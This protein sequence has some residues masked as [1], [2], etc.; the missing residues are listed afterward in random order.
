[1][2]DMPNNLVALLGTDDYVGVEP[3]AS[4]VNGK[5]RYIILDVDKPQKIF[6]DLQNIFNA[7]VGEKQKIL[8]IQFQR[9]GEPIPLN[10][11]Q[12]S[13]DGTYPS[14][15]SFH[16]VG[17]VMETN[18]PIVQFVMLDGMFQE[19]GDYVF[20]FSIQNTATGALET[21]HNCFFSVGQN[22]NSLAIDWNN[23][24]NPYDSE[25][26]EW[27]A[28]TEAQINQMQSSLNNFSNQVTNFKS[29]VNSYTS[30]VNDAVDT[31]WD[32][33]L[34]G[35]NTFTGTNTFNGTTAFA[36]TTHT[37]ADTFKSITT[38]GLSLNNANIKDFSG[39][40]ADGLVVMNNAKIIASSTGSSVGAS[41][42]NGVTTNSS[43]NGY[44]SFDV[45]RGKH[46][47]GVCIHANCKIPSTAVGKSI[48]QFTDTSS[49]NNIDQ[50]PFRLGDYIVKF[51]WS[52]NT[53]DC[54]GQ[55]SANQGND[56]CQG[57]VTII[58]KV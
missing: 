31:A 22:I 20:T 24:V 53:L 50:T 7:T 26:A 25:Y 39:N 12:V 14:G 3:N 49:I 9:S 33:K 58:S 5:L 52:A 55:I 2:S 23:G 51:N 35:N 45:F 42:L 47:L 11:I 13:M 4:V 34:S 27:K 16:V 1:M 15:L 41:F 6:Y 36:N 30:T 57:I 21:S 54:L 8:P 32:G 48:V 37:G 44:I 56:I 43:N 18:S 38:D 29:L 46:M 40:V 10:N 17:S 28:Q 19:V